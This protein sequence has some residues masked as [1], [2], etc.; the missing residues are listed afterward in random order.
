MNTPSTGASAAPF[1][2][3]WALDHSGRYVNLDN[4][5]LPP[6]VATAFNNQLAN[7]PELIYIDDD[8]NEQRIKATKYVEGKIP[9]IAGYSYD[10][11]KPKGIIEINGAKYANTYMAPRHEPITQPCNTAESLITN[12]LKHLLSSEPE[13]SLMLDWLAHQVQYP[14]QLLRFAPIIVGT[15]GDGKSCLMEIVSA[16]IGIHNTDQVYPRSFDSEFNDWANSGS[17]VAIEEL[18][19]RGSKGEQNYDFLK[20]FITNSQV[21]V[22]RKHNHPVTID[23]VTN[24]IAFSNHKD[25]I[26]LAG[27]DRRFWIMFTNFIDYAKFPVDSYTEHFTTLFGFITS[28]QGRA[29]VY[30]FLIHHSIS[31]EFKSLTAAPESISKLIMTEAAYDDLTKAVKE[32]MDH[33]EKP[34]ITYHHPTHGECINVTVINRME[35]GSSHHWDYPELPTGTKLTKAMDILGYIKLPGRRTINGVKSSLYKPKTTV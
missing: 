11:T 8:G 7:E 23:N 20:P 32:R 34:M 21:N 6:M 25:A 29:K 22:N 35:E 13:Q 19:I 14:G 5:S 33:Y 3:N 16:A 24:Y 27:D 10:P 28:A 31:Q 17:T 26:P 2:A 15:Q 12:H 9:T 1:Y 30:D 4:A 18:Y